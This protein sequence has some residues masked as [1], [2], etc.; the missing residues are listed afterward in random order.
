[1]GDLVVKKCGEVSESLWSSVGLILPTRLPGDQ[2]WQIF[3]TH[4]TDVLPSVR[5]IASVLRYLAVGAAVTTNR[6]S[7]VLVDVYRHWE[8]LL[9]SG[10]QIIQFSSPV[11]LGSQNRQSV[12]LYCQLWYESKRPTFRRNISSASSASSTGYLESWC[13][14]CI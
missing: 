9:S 10:V 13:I 2:F 3:E 11:S 6:P 12:A 14:A 1:M 8:P 7:G 5:D 4:G